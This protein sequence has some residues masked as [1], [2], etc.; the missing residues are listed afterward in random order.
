M[1]VLA[2]RTVRIA[3]LVGDVAL[4]S[5]SNGQILT[6]DSASGKWKNAPPAAADLSTAVL[7]AGRAGGQTVSG[8]TDGTQGLTLQGTSDAVAATNISSTSLNRIWNT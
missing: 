5:P 3:D 8:G 4:S 6:Y 1:A 7:L 2:T